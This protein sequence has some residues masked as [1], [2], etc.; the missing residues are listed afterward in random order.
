MVAILKTG[1]WQVI[2]SSRQGATHKLRNVCN[3]DAVAYRRVRD[4]AVV[5]VADGHGSS[6]SPYSD[7]G[8]QIAVS[9]TCR[10]LERFVLLHAKARFEVV[11]QR[12][13]MLPLAIVHAW[14]KEV[15]HNAEKKG[16]DVTN[17]LHGVW[18]Q[19]GCTLAA[20]AL[21]PEWILLLQVGDGDI[22]IVGGDGEVS[23]F[24]ENRLEDVGD[25]THS[26]CEPN[27][28]ARVGWR[29]L[30]IFDEK[31]LLL[32]CTDGYSKAFATQEDFLKSGSDWLRLLKEF[33]ATYI[34]Q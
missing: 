29:L 2:A 24:T 31:P 4:G 3:Q 34:E 27:A 17:N 30:P 6:A 16:L 25:A 15:M 5:A 14:R 1:R 22:L 33:D 20:A 18:L 26:L 10:C 12:A 9:T 28:E 32:L 19:F 8:A 23:R 7:T 13:A 11:H 21:H